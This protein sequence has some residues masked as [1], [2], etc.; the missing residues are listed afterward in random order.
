MWPFSKRIL[1]PEQ[2]S[3]KPPVAIGE[4]FKY[5]GIEMV[6]S[7]HWEWPYECPVVVGE[8]VTSIGRI[9]RAIFCPVDWIA[10]EAER[11]R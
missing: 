4:R 7:R 2:P 11:A 10:L 6:C 1:K 3:R 5:L 9:E 8:Y